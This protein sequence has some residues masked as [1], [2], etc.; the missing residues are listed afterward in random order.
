MSA[1]APSLR[2]ATPEGVVFS[3]QLATPVSRGLAWGLDA[4]AIGGVSFL[5]SR[6]CTIAGFLSSDFANFLTAVL[7][8]VISVGYGILLDWRWRGQTLG[9]RIFGLRVVDVGYLQSCQD[10]ERAGGSSTALTIR[11]CFCQVP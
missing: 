11:I 10:W 5:V 2:I 1:A 6:L 9:K 8:F 3:Y 7:Y 4:T